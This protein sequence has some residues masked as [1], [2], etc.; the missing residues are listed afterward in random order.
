MSS[1]IKTYII[2]LFAT[3]YAIVSMTQS[4]QNPFEIVDRLEGGEIVIPENIEPVDTD[5]DTSRTTVVIDTSASENTNSS[6]ENIA[7]PNSDNPFEIVERP[8]EAAVSSAEKTIPN[9]IATPSKKRTQPKIK[10][11]KPAGKSTP[12]R[13]QFFIVMLITLIPMTL[14]FTVFR[15]YFMKAYEN[16]TNASVLNR[17]YREF[18]GASIIPMNLWYVA[19]WINLGIF[20]SLVMNYYEATFTKSPLLNVLICI[21]IIGGLHLLKHFVLGIM[22]VIFPVTKEAKLYAFLLLLFGIM[23]GVFLV[24]M[25]IAIIYAADRMTKLLIFGALAIMGTLYLIRA[26][27]GLLVSGRLAA[28]H[29]FHFLLYICVVELAPIFILIK[30]GLIYLGK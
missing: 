14:L 22:A 27:R 30:L 19:S 21:G 29:K 28:L 18:A 2:Y 11:I 6:E 20:L 9:I 3:F 26:Y 24:P 1:S 8:S 16:V 15:D 10:N 12:H 13:G 4:T 5:V 23:I 17:S 7:L 25:N